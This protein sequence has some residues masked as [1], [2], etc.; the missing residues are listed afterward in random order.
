[1]KT[2][3]NIL[4]K[5]EPRLIWRLSVL[6]VVLICVAHVLAK[7]NVDLKPLLVIPV[8][9]ASWY[10]GRRTGAATAVFASISLLL[11]SYFLGAGTIDDYSVVYDAL[12]YFMVCIFI[13]VVVTNFKK[14]HA[15]EKDAADTDSLTGLYSSRRFYSELKAEILRS[16]RYGHAVSL[17]Y[18]D[19]DNFKKINDTLGH[20]IGD[21]LLM[22][23]SDCLIDALRSTDVVAR[24]G[25]D[26]FVCL[27]PET[28]EAEARS[29][30]S[31]VVRTLKGSMKKHGWDVSFSIGVVTFEEIPDDVGQ[32][33]KLADDLMYQVKNNNKND[34]AFRVWRGVA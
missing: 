30:M 12:V 2:I 13:S 23:L 3:F 33:V 22:R 7:Q 4:D 21:E 24:L 14:V 8:L 17:A 28:A 31:K 15:V 6:S 32:A 25:G 5:R 18:V 1:M 16:K 9:L 11:A 10:G 29:A 19:V 20:P 34:I 27:L 26:E